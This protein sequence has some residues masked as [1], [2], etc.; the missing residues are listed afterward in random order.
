M[1]SKSDKNVFKIG[2]EVIA[3][4]TPA[5]WADKAIKNVI[6]KIIEE[7]KGRCSCQLRKN[8]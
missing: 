6:D 2:D 1:K 3:R 5:P 7:E 4:A 8:K